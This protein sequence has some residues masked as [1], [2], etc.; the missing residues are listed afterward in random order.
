[1]FG[2]GSDSLLNT[3]VEC[4]V[5]GVMNMIRSRRNEL[6][7]YRKKMYKL[8]YGDL[9]NTHTHRMEA[10]KINTNKQAKYRA[11]NTKHFKN[12]VKKVFP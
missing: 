8:H 5:I 6:L 2:V 7:M 9:R 12:F 11:S 10:T 1:M 4:A 3:S